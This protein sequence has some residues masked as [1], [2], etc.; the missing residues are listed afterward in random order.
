M[1]NIL[2][3][4]VCIISLTVS[5]QIPDGTYKMA[6]VTFTGNTISS[7]DSSHEVDPT[8][9]IDIKMITNT[10]LNRW[11]DAST[12][13]NSGYPHYTLL[14]YLINHVWIPQTTDA[15]AEGVT[16]QYYSMSKFNSALNSKTTDNLS[17]G[18]L[19]KYYSDVLARNAF[20]V[21]SPLAYNNSTGVFSISS[22]PNSSL[23]NSNITI[24]GNSIALGGS[25]TITASPSINNPTTGT[26]ITMGTAFQPR[27][28]GPCWIAI[29][30]SLTGVLGLNETIAVSMSS[31]SGGTYTTVT[32][33]VLLIGLLGLTL[34]R[35]VSSIPV[36]SGWWVKVTRSG[37]ASN[38]TYTKWDL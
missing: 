26:S 4:L 9:D 10:D 27:S 8:V 18:L 35:T 12:L 19:R 16:N 36:P 25:T 30:G 29:N 7:I 21:N 32:T 28:T 24:N 14:D 13:I 3:F 17:E 37:T 2:L 34:D 1:K 15:L 31:T 33:D 23:A 11:N 20:S 22:I 38:A 6:T 5:S